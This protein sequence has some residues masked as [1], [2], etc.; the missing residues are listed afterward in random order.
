ICK[1]DVPELSYHHMIPKSQGGTETTGI[2]KDCHKSIHAFFTNKELARTYHTIEALLGHESFA[3]HIGWLSKQDPAKRFKTKK[4]K[5]K[6]KR[7]AQVNGDKR[8]RTRN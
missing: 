6:R 5:D 7:G 4:N 3:K 8:S 1:R 2:C